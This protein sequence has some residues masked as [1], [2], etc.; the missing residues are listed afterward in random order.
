MLAYLRL[1]VDPDD[2][3]SFQRV[4]NVPRRRIGPVTLGAFF[5]WLQDEGLQTGEALMAL[6]N[7]AEPQQLTRRRRELFRNFSRLLFRD[8]RILAAQDQFTRLLD[9]IREQTDYDRYIDRYSGTTDQEESPKAR[10]R[11]RNI[12]LLR[13]DL[14]R[15]EREGQTLKQ[16]LKTSGLAQA[17]RDR[18]RDAVSLMT[19]HGAKGLE[20]PVVFIAG[21]EEGLL[22]DYRAAK[23]PTRLEEERRLFY[24]GMTRAEDELYLTWATHRNGRSNQPSGFLK[25]LE[26]EEAGTGSAR[27]R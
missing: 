18:E 26:S 22:P 16:Y 13:D 21:L 12:D 20:F 17:F 24:V 27:G 8:W 9:G 15:A 19:L 5:T 1:C 23:E 3:V 10:E 11:K 7:G 2:R 25:E 14:E 6:L 4:I